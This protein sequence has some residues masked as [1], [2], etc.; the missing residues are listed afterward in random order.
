MSDYFWS[1]ESVRCEFDGA[2]RRV[3]V[4]RHT[5]DGSLACDTFFSC[6]ANCRV[7]GRYAHGYVTSTEN[8]MEF[9]I[10]D[11]S[12]ARLGLLVKESVA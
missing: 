1:R 8:G 7:G 4:R 6:P 11:A 12:R 9:R 2:V 10:H 5:F 3:R